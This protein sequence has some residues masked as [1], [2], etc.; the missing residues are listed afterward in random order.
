ML[1]NSR[2][3]ASEADLGSAPREVWSLA[4]IWRWDWISASRPGR[5]LRSERRER[6]NLFEKFMGYGPQSWRS[7]RI[8]SICIARNAGVAEAAMAT[9]TSATATAVKVSGSVGLVL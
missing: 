5:L 1:P 6:K 8:G 3:A 4:A 7:A 9:A 2:R